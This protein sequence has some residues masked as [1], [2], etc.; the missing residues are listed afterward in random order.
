MRLFKQGKSNILFDLCVYGILLF[1]LFV[2]GYPM[3]VVVSSSF[4]SGSAIME[5]KV[6]FLPV[7]FTLAGYKSFFKTQR[8]WIGMKN[9]A[10]YTLVGTVI[11]LCLTILAAYPLSRSHLRGRKGLMLFFL[12]TTWFGAGLIPSYLLMKDLHVVNTMWA[13]IVPGALSVHYVIILRTTFEGLPEALRESAYLDGCGE[14]QYLRKIALPL[15]R[16]TVA[17]LTLYYGVSHWNNYATAK[18]YITKNELQPLQSVLR[19]IIL[20]GETQELEM[21]MAQEGG[22][23]V[24]ASAELLKYASVVVSTI[25]VL[26]VYPFVQRHLVKGVLMGAV[27]G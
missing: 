2:I 6:T 4:S 15:S 21:M 14:F 25:P 18:I 22:A 5:G 10:V 9:S 1:L 17:V 11:N 23:A 20:L 8:I 13:M 24:A 16:A 12:F 7:D 3:L 27:K 26:L 19:S